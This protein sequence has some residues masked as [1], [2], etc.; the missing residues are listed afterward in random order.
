[1]HFHTSSL[2]DVIHKLIQVGTL[3]RLLS[4][5]SVRRSLKFPLLVHIALIIPTTWRTVRVDMGHFPATSQVNNLFYQI[6][7]SKWTFVGTDYTCDA[8]LPNTCEYSTYL[9]TSWSLNTPKIQ[10]VPPQN[11]WKSAWYCKPMDSLINNNTQ[12]LH[13][14]LTLSE[15]KC[16]L[17]ALFPNH[18]LFQESVKPCPTT[19]FQP[20]V[21]MSHLLEDLWKAGVYGKHNT[22]KAPMNAGNGL[23]QPTE[24]KQV[25]QNFWMTPWPLLKRW[26]E[27]SRQNSQPSFVILPTYVDTNPQDMGGAW[28]HC[29]IEGI[30]CLKAWPGTCPSR[31]RKETSRLERR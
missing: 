19:S 30:R 31:C 28:S 24:M 26:L 5:P 22:K 18:E 27:S 29:T 11:R 20:P 15:S 6:Q 25:W 16:L 1:M 14:W 8:I 9:P 3:I 13:W 17:S 23:H 10:S 2:F 7:R 12:D 4:I 21:N